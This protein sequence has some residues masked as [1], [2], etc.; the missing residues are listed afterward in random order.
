MLSNIARRTFAV[1]H[2]IEA[3]I[4]AAAMLAIATLT[5]ANV[6]TRTFFGQSIAATEELSQFLI[7]LICFVGLSY[8]ASQGR[9]IRMNVFFDM[10]PPRPRKALMIFIA[11]TTAALMFYLAWQAVLYVLVV[12]ELGSVSPVLQV[13]LYIVYLSAP[14]GLA[15]AGIQYVLTVAKNLTAP[16]I[17][18][19]FDHMDHYIDEAEETTKGI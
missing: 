7:I 12:A 17:Y 10:L 9:H 19:S 18:L 2:A 15:L 13:P 8:A 1:V 5:I 14:A 4:L 3:F 16:D 6:I 11:A